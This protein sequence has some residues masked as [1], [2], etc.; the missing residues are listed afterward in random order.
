[1]AMFTVGNG[2]EEALRRSNRRLGF[3]AQFQF[4]CKNFQSSIAY[5]EMN[6]CFE[7]TIL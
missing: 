4:N 3:V 1:M 2:G 6:I 5:G 7:L